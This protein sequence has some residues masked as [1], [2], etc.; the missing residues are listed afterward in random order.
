M[1]FSKTNWDRLAALYAPKWRF[2]MK[3]SFIITTFLGLQISLLANAQKEISLTVKKEPLRKVLS[4]IEKNSDYRFLYTDA[5]VFETSRITLN[6]KNAPIGEVLIKVLEGTGLEYK[7]NNNELVV[8]SF[9]PP[10]DNQQPITGKVTDESGSPVAGATIQVK[11]SSQTTITDVD[12]NFTIDVDPNATLIIS[13]VGY[14]NKEIAIAGKTTLAISLERDQKNLSEVI[15]TALGI[16]RNT[17]ALQFSAT[18]VDGDNFTQA[19]EN[20]TANALAGRVAGVNVTKIASGRRFFES[21]YQG[22]K[23]TGFF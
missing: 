19:R 13:S 22:S 16:E 1:L 12:G 9:T 8:L 6:V 20:N 14:L 7:I 15:V 21:C 2:I 11:G 5:P 3:I 17:K 23:N 4:L 18:K 10:S